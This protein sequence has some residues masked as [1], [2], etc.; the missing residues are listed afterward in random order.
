[1]IGGWRDRYRSNDRGETVTGKLRG[2]NIWEYKWGPPVD[3]SGELPE[4]GAFAGIDEF[5]ALL[6]E[7]TD[8]VAHSVVSQLLVYS[9]GQKI[10]IADREVV[11][12]IVEQTRS[13]DYGLRSI[14]H[15]IVQSETFRSK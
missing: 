15:E 8:Q 2:R 1:M 5:K 14:I 11:D 13:G 9:T 6:L 4:G 10:E 3:A 12:R 7:Q